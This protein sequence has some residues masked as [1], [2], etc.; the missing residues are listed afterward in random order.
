M[1]KLLTSE[2]TAAC[3]MVIHR[4]SIGNRYIKRDFNYTYIRIVVK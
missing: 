4:F 1:R 3:H 2:F